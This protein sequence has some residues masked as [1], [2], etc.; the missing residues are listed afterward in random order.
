MIVQVYM[1]RVFCICVSYPIRE[2]AQT[3]FR[4]CEHCA[5]AIGVGRLVNT[6]VFAPGSVELYHTHATRFRISS[7]T[8]THA[9]MSKNTQT[10]HTRTHRRTPARSFSLYLRSSLAQS[11]PKEIHTHKLMRLC[12]SKL[13]HTSAFE[14]KGKRRAHEL[15]INN[16]NNSAILCAI[17]LCAGRFAD[18]VCCS[19]GRGCAVPLLVSTMPLW[20]T[21]SRVVLRLRSWAHGWN[22]WSRSQERTHIANEC[23]S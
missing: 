12:S 16:G 21:I 3:L 9:Q 18:N 11:D 10:H 23:P 15:Y 8:T 2:C 13:A 1:L 22:P 17:R 7:R 6:A 14:H 5:V 20:L 4:V 19:G